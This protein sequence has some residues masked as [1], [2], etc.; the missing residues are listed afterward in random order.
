[1]YIY[2]GSILLAFIFQTAVARNRNAKVGRKAADRASS[3]PSLTASHF[4]EFLYLVAAE[5]VMGCV[6]GLCAM[7]VS[8]AVHFS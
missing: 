7:A 5:V 1:M 3:C 4:L 8:T 2:I 6:G